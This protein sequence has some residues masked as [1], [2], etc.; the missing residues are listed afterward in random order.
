MG[1]TLTVTNAGRAALVD[2]SNTGTAPVTIAE[3]GLTGT[4][5]TPDP[6]ATALPGE[7]KRIATLSGDV[8]ADDTI[9]LIVRDETGDV[10]TVRSLALYLGDGTLFAIYGQA[11]VLVEKSAQAL[12]LLAIDVQFADVDA[13]DL[14]FGDANFL[15]PP[16]TTEQ[17][18]VVELSTLAE[19]IGG[20]SASRVPAEKMV[21]DAVNAW[22]DARFGAN[23]AGIWHPGNDGAGSGLDAD[24]LDGQQGSWYSNIPARLGYNPVQQG[25]GNGQLAGNVI[26]IGWSSA[27]R[28][29]ATV[30]VTDQGNLVTDPYLAAGAL[31]VNGAAMRRGGYDVW[32]PDNDGAGSGLDADLLDGQHGSAFARLNLPQSQAFSGNLLVG[33]GQASGFEGGQIDFAKA[34][35]GAMTGDPSIDIYNNGFRMIGPFSG[36]TRTLEFD[37]GASGGKVWHAGNDGAGSG[38]DADLLDGQHGSYYADIPARLGYTPFNRAG[39]TVTG[40]LAVSG[41]GK[42][43]FSSVHTSEK[44]IEFERSGQTA[45][46]YGSAS[47]LGVYDTQYGEVWRWGY[48]STFTIQG[49]LAWTAGND[50]AG[51]GLDADLLDGQQGAYY[52]DIPARL[53]YTPVSKSGDSFTNVLSFTSGDSQGIA[54]RP[55]D[56]TPLEVRG[57][58]TGAAVMTFHRPGSF[59]AFLG[60]DTDNSL[61]FGGWSA[62]AVSHLLWHSGNDGSGSGLDADLLDGQQGSYYADIP[63]R[64]GYTPVQQGGGIGQG[65]NKIY[66]GWSGARL[67]ATVD[68]TDQG[69]LVT[70]PNLNGNVLNIKGASMWRGA[71]NLWG[72][73]NDG[74][75]SGLDADLLDGQHASA[76]AKM[77]DFA[78][79]LSAGGYQ[80][81]PGGLVLQWV[82]GASGA[83]EGSQ[84]LNWPL[85]FTAVIDAFVSTSVSY[86]SSSA[87]VWFQLVGSPSNNGCTVM[88]GYSG[89]TGE[90]AAAPVVFALGRI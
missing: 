78:G 18:G 37:F 71:Y 57:N 75:G 19:A 52:A 28:L 9:H 43:L 29:K 11:D 87:D 84:A 77:A 89:N 34:P 2:A 36:G 83:S 86:A 35:S 49:A 44:H 56:S 90:V 33:M 48:G 59:A 39:D 70:E 16:A 68:S 62:G 67:K 58:G 66:I 76:F 10:F 31:T 42:I 81:L 21:K 73:D 61:R 27:S 14:T 25:T 79:D 65:T 54:S 30:D 38:L 50:G 12:M 53:G 4:A 46:M 8:V 82:R 17:M 63:A 6:G 40:T 26:K 7:F 32:G 69:A 72:P 64:L 88:R 15:N 22:L 74:A 55:S 45:Y 41:S 60:L 51:S 1:L 5:V 23:N 24:L 20:T 3:V 47:G 13:T 85:T 80:K